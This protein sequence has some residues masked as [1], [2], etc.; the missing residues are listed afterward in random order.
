MQQQADRFKRSEDI[1]TYGIAEIALREASRLGASDVSVIVGQTQDNLVRFSN[2]EITLTNTVL[3]VGLEVYFAKNRRRMIGA[4]SNI[5]GDSISRFVKQLHDSCLSLPESPDYAPLPPVASKFSERN[6]F[7]AGLEQNGSELVQLTKDCLS[8]ALEAGANRVSG[9]LTSAI[10]KVR[11][12]TSTGTDGVDSSTRVLLNVRA[13]S[14]SDASGHGLSCSFSLQ[15]FDPAEAG[16]IAGRYAKQAVGAKELPQGNYD[17]ILSPT[18]FADIM[19]HVGA[20]ASAFSVLS[21][22]SFFE[23]MLEKSIANPNLSV[24]DVGI[25]EGTFGGRSFDDEG[26][27]TQETVILDK[28]ILKNYLHNSTTARAFQA[29]STGSAGIIDPHPWNLFVAPGDSSFEEIVKETRNGVIVTNNWYT[30][31][32]N[33]RMG[34]YSTVPRDAAFLVENGEVK[35]AIVGIRISDSIPR[36]LKNIS[37]MSEERKW[38]EWWEVHTPTFAPWALVKD[39]LITKALT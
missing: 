37:L 2:N 5:D 33:Y 18:V 19:Q 22:S 12:A 3:N 34:E 14:D 7:D 21:G 9:S 31:F 17:V 32:H 39:V 38:I 24:T 15:G 28:G 10:E 6:N 26:V 13:F 4:T 25:G 36:Q 29:K 23:G 8:S 1:D 27:P 20:F 35:H 16:K 11:I 30:R